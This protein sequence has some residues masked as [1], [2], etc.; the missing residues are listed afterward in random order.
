MRADSESAPLKAVLLFCPGKELRAIKDPDAAQHLEVIDPVKIRRDFARMAAA[1]GDF[2]VTVHFLDPGPLLAGKA[3][4]KFNLMY[5]RDLFFNTREG[6]I[7]SRMAST[8]RQGEE[9]FAQLALARL[10]VPIHKTISHD[11]LFEAADAIWLDPRTVLCGTGY[12]TNASGARQLGAVLKLQGVSTL[13]VKL[14]KCVQ[15]L[16]GLVQ[17]VDRNLALVRTSLAPVR[18]LRIL[19]KKGFKILPVPES[20]EVT[21]QQGMNV[22]TV[23]PRQLFMPAGCPALKKLYLEAG[24]RVA[25][26]IPIPELIKG[27]GGLSCATGILARAPD[28]RYPAA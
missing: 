13:V 16:M 20:D 12:R 26:E 15:H 28:T 9:K 7:L 17:L 10:A 23:R 6:A 3:L 4:D 21:H 27:A 24:I 11:G 18:L 22:V 25:R 19:R 2:G 14:P 5:V 8:V 1:Y